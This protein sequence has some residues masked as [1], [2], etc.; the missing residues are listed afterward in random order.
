MFRGSLPQLWNTPQGRKAIVDTL[1]R[2]NDYKIERAQIAEE[3][4]D[5]NMTYREFYR[6]LRAVKDPFEKF[7]GKTSGGPT[8]AE[9]GRQSVRDPL[10]IRGG[11]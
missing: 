9:A 7:R 3:F 1:R 6:R 5:G 8:P 4:L 11:R 10:G 2:L